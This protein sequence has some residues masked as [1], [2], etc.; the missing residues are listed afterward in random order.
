MR[1]L[2]L[3]FLFFSNLYSHFLLDDFISED[4]LTFKKASFSEYKNKE[5]KEFTIKFNPD[6]AIGK[7]QSKQTYY[8]I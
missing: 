3:L 4:N 6:Y 5:L 7:F 1:Y 2:I 8:K